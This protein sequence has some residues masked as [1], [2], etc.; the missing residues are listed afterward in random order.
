MNYRCFL[1]LA[2]CCTLAVCMAGYVAFCVLVRGTI[3]LGGNHACA[4]SQG[5]VALVIFGLAFFRFC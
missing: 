2:L 1:G 3:W 4:W 5:V